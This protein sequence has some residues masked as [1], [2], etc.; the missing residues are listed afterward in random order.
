M[1]T[2]IYRQI[3]KE[4][5]HLAWRNKILWLFG[6]FAGML[7][8]GGVYDL[9]IKMF[10]R[11]TTASITWESI[12]NNILPPYAY[13]ENIVAIKAPI[14]TAGLFSIWVIFVLIAILAL[15]LFLIWLSI[16]SQ[17]TLI[18]AVSQTAA[19]KKDVIKN[20]FRVGL[21][22]FWSLLGINALLKLAIVL[23]VVF[24]SFPLVLLLGKSALLNALL[25]LT[26]FV[27]FLPLA[28]IIYF[29]A[30]LASCY[31][32]LR[33]KRFTE[34]IHFAWVLFKRN[35]LICLELGFLLFIVGFLV[36]LAVVL[37]FLIASIPVVLLLL[38]ALALGSEVASL[39]VI[40]LAVMILVALVILSGAF[41]VTFQYTSWVMLFERLTTKGGVSRLVRWLAGAETL[42]GKPK[43]KK[44]TVRRKT[45]T[46]RR[47]K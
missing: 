34:S 33:N 5:W 10:S 27:I 19:K 16:A 14:E 37:I 6:F 40:A 22:K 30:I 32:V 7:I 39:L 15:G 35:W 1:H 13:V 11:V 47:K 4:A 29:V 28:I 17:G 41:V 38:A 18:Y 25:Y 24:T 45:G 9:A 8:N 43:P 42:H 23:L 12:M 36:G 20:S 26:S 3:I 46:S 31:L 21:E 2:P 44:K